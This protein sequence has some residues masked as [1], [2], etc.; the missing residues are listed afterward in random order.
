MQEILSEIN[1]SSFCRSLF[2]PSRFL[3]VKEP[4][5]KKTK[6]KKGSKKASFRRGSSRKHE[7]KSAD[8]MDVPEVHGLQKKPYCLNIFTNNLI[9]IKSLRK[10]LK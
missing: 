10:L 9:Q 7:P 3:Q 6:S 2:F 1:R 5:K 4:A 8:G